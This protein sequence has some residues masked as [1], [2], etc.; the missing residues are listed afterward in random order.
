[1][2]ERVRGF[3]LEYIEE[4]RATLAGNVGVMALSW[5]LF[6]LSGALVQPF[7][8]IYA[9][10]LGASDFELAFIRTLGMLSL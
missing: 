2:L 7:F 9:K 4:V 10:E 1:M 5:F 6:A 8:S 3:I